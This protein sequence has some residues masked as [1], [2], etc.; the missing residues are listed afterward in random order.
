MHSLTL[1]MD[2]EMFILNDTA[3]ND[4]AV[5]LA[6]ANYTKRLQAEESERQAI[7]AG[8]IQPQPTT[9]WNISDRD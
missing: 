9:V 8:L 2:S 3:K 6:I 1:S 5:Q 4:S 7:R